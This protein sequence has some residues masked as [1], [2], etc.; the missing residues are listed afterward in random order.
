[1]TRLEVANLSTDE[2]L[3]F[4]ELFEVVGRRWSVAVVLAAAQGSERFGEFRGAV[5][6]ISERL[7]TERLRELTAHGILE[8]TVIGEP[9]VIR[10]RLTECGTDLVERLNPVIGWAERWH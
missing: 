6:G 3:R 10:Y 1:M 7:L 4:Q 5:P 8:R 9:A 2:C